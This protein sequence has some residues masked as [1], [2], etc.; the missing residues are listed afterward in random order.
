MRTALMAGLVAT[1]VIG[2]MGLGRGSGAAMAAV[3]ADCTRCG[4]MMSG[5]GSSVAQA[6]SSSAAWLMASSSTS[7]TTG[8]SCACAL[9]PAAHSSA[10][11]MAEARD[12]RGNVMAVEVMQCSIRQVPAGGQPLNC[13]EP[14]AVGID[15]TGGLA[16]C[17]ST[18][19]AARSSRASRGGV[20]AAFHN[21]HAVAVQVFLGN[22]S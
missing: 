20:T 6:S 9:A 4:S 14:K 1:T 21:R 11:V 17:K 15:A 10:A 12:E 18:R 16:A 13:H 8:P 22:G 3:I 7:P 19:G 2:T 5:L